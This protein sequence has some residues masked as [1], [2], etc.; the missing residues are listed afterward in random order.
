MKK[1]PEWQ[2]PLYRSWDKELYKK[3][4]KLA[5]SKKY[6]KII[7][8]Q[9]DIDI[10]LKTMIRTQ[11]MSAWRTFFELIYDDLDKEVFDMKNINEKAK[12]LEIKEGIPNWATL[13][14]QKRI[15]LL[16]DEIGKQKISFIGLEE[17]TFE[18]ILRFILSQLLI[19]WETPLLAIFLEIED[20]EKIETKKLNKLFGIWDYTKVFE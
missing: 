15:C 1:I 8:T 3:I 13:G 7:G 6:P 2:Y 14:H 9:G 17:E 18:F 4:E 11:K 16:N 5:K 19:S 20:K 10:F 12:D